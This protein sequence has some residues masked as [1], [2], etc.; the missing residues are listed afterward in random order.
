VPDRIRVTPTRSSAKSGQTGEN[1]GTAFFYHYV[2]TFFIL[3]LFICIL[4]CLCLQEPVQLTADDVVAATRVESADADEHIRLV[5]SIPKKR[6][7]PDAVRE[8]LNLFSPR[9]STSK[10]LSQSSQPSSAPP[11]EETSQT[12]SV[13]GGH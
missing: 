12:A 3:C 7:L 1:K 2:R 4:Q 11:V 6:K 9:E 5:V 10:K 13:E 8:A